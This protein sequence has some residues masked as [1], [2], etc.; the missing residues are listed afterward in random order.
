MNKLS[1]SKLLGER[2]E[3][4]VAVSAIRIISAKPEEVV[5]QAEIEIFGEQPST[6]LVSIGL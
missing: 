6:A 1:L 5:L 3:A 2:Y 4:T